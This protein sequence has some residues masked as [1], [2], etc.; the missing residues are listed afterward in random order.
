MEFNIFKIAM[1]KSEFIQYLNDKELKKQGKE[2]KYKSEIIVDDKVIQM[3]FTSSFFLKIDEN[4]SEIEWLKYWSPYYN[5]NSNIKR[6]IE[7]AYGMIM[8][9]ANREV[10]C[11][12]LGRGHHYASNVAD[13]DFGFG[14]DIA[15]IIHD[16]NSIGAKN[17]RFWLKSK[18]LVKI[19]NQSTYAV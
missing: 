2:K 1:K 7:S 17:S 3:Q 10:F 15:E 13:L 14:F 11:I 8:I 12:S 9:T 19:Q 16:S 5:F 6:A 18:I 4:D